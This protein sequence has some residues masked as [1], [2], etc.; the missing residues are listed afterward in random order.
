MTNE[1]YGTSLPNN[2]ANTP[3]FLHHFDSPGT[4]LDFIDTTL[5]KLELSSSSFSLCNDMVLSWIFNALSKD[6]QVSVIYASTSF[7]FWS[8]LRDRFWQSNAPHIFQLK[9]FLATFQQG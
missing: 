8:D 7:E 1:I 6:L 3:Y 2:D 5:S 9:Q 4:V